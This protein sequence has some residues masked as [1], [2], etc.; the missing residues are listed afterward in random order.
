MEKEKKAKKTMPWILFIILIISV[1]F[2]VVRLFTKDYQGDY[3]LILIQALTGILGMLAPGF[4][5]RKFELEIPSV[6]YF[7]LLFF[8]L[9]NSFRRIP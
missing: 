1:I 4:I 7:S 9:F 2:I 8:F 6:M 5:S 3:I